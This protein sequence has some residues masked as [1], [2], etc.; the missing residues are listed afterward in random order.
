MVKSTNF[1]WSY[2]PLSMLKNGFLLISFERIGVLDSNLIHK[3]III[4][5][6]SGPIK[7]K[8]HLLFL[9]LWPFFKFEK[10]STL[11]NGFRAISLER[12]GVLD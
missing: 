7:G 4:K 6:C 10:F 3:Y 8:I 1:F 11:E 9:E 2:G 5:C 12:I